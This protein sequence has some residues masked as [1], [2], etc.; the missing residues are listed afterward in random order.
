M[1]KLRCG[2]PTLRVQ[3]EASTDRCASPG[4]PHVRAV[5]LDGWI[6]L[7]ETNQWEV[8]LVASRFCLAHITLEAKAA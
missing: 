2:M 4:C 7:P 5:A 6:R 1:D 8:V 3:V